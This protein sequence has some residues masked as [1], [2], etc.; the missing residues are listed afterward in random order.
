MLGAL[1]GY[2]TYSLWSKRTA[3]WNIRELP[4]LTTS[5][6]HV[7]V[8]MLCHDTWFYYG[9]RLLHHRLIYKHIH[10]VHHEWTAPIAP[11]ALYAHPVE[12]ILTG[13]VSASFYD[14]INSTIFMI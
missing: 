3:G 8:S 14:N 6:L 13:Q 2:A 5:L 12:H 4:D 10:K 11:A 7:F 1:S 9:H